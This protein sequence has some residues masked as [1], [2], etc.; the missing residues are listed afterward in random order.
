VV[1]IFRVKSKPS[2]KQEAEIYLPPACLAY[3]SALKMEAMCFSESSADFHQAT[4]RCIPDRTLQCH[5]CENLKFN[6][7]EE[8]R[9][10]PT[11]NVWRC[12]TIVLW[13]EKINTRTAIIMPAVRGF[14]FAVTVS[15]DEI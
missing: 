7:I 8:V 3:V 14:H 1:S 4:R 9:E 6:A 15:G 5:R 10:L 11:S 12:R 13:C 2:K